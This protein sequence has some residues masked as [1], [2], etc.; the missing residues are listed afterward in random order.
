MVV[1]MYHTSGAEVG[2]TEE[3]E[4][5]L[6][7]GVQFSGGVLG[8]EHTGPGFE[9]QPN[10]SPKHT[11]KYPQNHILGG[12]QNIKAKSWYKLVE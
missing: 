12:K 11:S 5:L 2:R 8:L 4:M 7:L 6:G 3:K 9:P 1:Y 10:P